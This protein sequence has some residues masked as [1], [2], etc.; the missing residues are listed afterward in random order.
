VFLERIATK[1]GL[2]QNGTGYKT[3]LWGKKLE[4]PE[5]IKRVL[6]GIVLDS[7]MEEN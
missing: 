5:S 1:R 3:D 6:W 7:F 2:R 4:K